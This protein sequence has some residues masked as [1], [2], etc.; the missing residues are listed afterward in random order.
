MQNLFQFYRRILNQV[1]Q[2]I[3]LNEHINNIKKEN[4]SDD[5]YLLGVLFRSFCGVPSF[6]FTTTFLTLGNDIIGNG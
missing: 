2:I 1:T 6:S 5:F 4:K 3:Y